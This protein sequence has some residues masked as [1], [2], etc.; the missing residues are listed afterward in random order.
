MGLL[1]LGACTQKPPRTAAAETGNAI[2]V[3]IATP[4]TV[5]E[6]AIQVSGQVEAVQTAH[7][8][9]R[10]M[11]Y[12]TSVK[13]KAGDHVTK[14]QLL[15]TVSNEDM[16]ARRAA[17]D[18]MIAEAEAA[19]KN[20]RKD[21]D[22]F[23][24]L[25]NQ[26]S[27]TAKELENMQLQYSTAQAKLEQA[28]QMRNEAGAA[29]SYTRLVAPFTGVVTQKLMDAGS[30]ATPGMPV[31]V[32]ENSSACQVSVAVPESRIGRLKPDAVATIQLD[33]AGK[34][35]QGRVIQIN[36][37][38]TL[39]GGQ[40]EVKIA[41][42]DT[43]KRGVLAGMYATVTIPV[44]DT[45][46]HAATHQVLVPAS[47]LVQKDQLTGLYTIASNNTALLRWVTTGK[48]T[49]GQVQILSGLGAEEVFIV[50]ASAT[51]YNGAPVIVKK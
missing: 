10:V 7:I 49:G 27:A 14:G 6:Q 4:Y 12:L 40:Y 43:G 9:T 34:T 33:A 11:G 24:A 47:A 8:S 50:H 16:V 39:T 2:E 26:Q 20:A 35:I 18:A 3:T 32:I 42:P 37:S 17:A 22:R 51:L 38:A 31:V 19:C 28:R 44:A 25:Y 23:T 48:T 15:A 1:L 30:M 29:L 45:A 46:A 36:P 41:I 5:G 13:V 21:A